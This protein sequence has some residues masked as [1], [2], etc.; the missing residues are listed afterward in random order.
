MLEY[1]VHRLFNR[2]LPNS[3]SL[4]ANICFLPA[5]TNLVK[6]LSSDKW[7][8]LTHQSLKVD[9][10][11]RTSSFEVYRE[12]TQLSRTLPDLFRGPELSSHH[13]HGKFTTKCLSS[14]LRS[15]TLFWALKA[16][17]DCSPFIYIQEGKSTFLKRKKIIWD[18]R[19]GSVVKSAHCSS[20]GPCIL[21]PS[22][23]QSLR[24]I[25]NFSYKGSDSII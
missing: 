3:L 2:I 10:K 20:K 12:M 7:Q 6:Q 15:D 24:D 23:T 25:H 13:P 5:K 18:W 14:S 21:L 1:C 19:N 4:L 16:P 22:P 11:L 9:A 17:N 8:S